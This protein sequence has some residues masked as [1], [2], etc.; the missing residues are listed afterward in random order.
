MKRHLLLLGLLISLSGYSQQ[1]VLKSVTDLNDLETFRS[2]QPLSIHHLGNDFLVGTLSGNIPEGTTVLKQDPWNAGADY[3]LVWLPEGN[4]KAALDKLAGSS[5]L[6]YSDEKK[7]IVETDPASQPGP[8]P[9]VHGGVVRISPASSWQPDAIRSFNYVIDTFPEIYNLIALVDTGEFMPTI[10]HLESYGTRYCELPQAVEAQ[11]WIKAKFEEYQALQV[12][13]QDFPFGSGS[14][15]NVIATLPGKVTP[16]QY[17][18]VGSHY[19]SYAWGGN[20]PGADDNASGTAAVLELAR[21]LSQF[22]FDKSIVFC[23]FSAEEVGLV[24]SEYYASHAQQQ[25][26]DILGYFNFDMISY[27]HGNDPIHTDMIAP[28]SAS[29]LVNFYKGVVA[30][31]LPDFQVYSAQLSGGDSDHTSF[32]NNGYMG[33]FPF[34]DVPNYSPYIHTAQD[35]VGISVNSP[36]MASTFIQANLA[37]VVSLAVP[38]N[39][40]GIQDKLIDRTTLH[41]FP[42]PATSHV[43]LKSLVKESQHVSIYSSHGQKVI[44]QVVTGQMTIDI[45]SLSAGVYIV[46]GI[47]TAGSAFHRLII[48]PSK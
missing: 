29:E 10:R 5:K 3:F 40:V 42:N 26:M 46:K 36:E 28:L 21:I 13:L 48:G 24:G 32:N 43:T 45:T 1:L 44:E 27:R 17:I 23:T 22:E 7:A 37:S 31:Y 30:I 4:S 15:D 6:L 9:F 33:I 47:S 18:V 12:E 8:E 14:S 16:D 35:V 25:G 19:D 34:E 38:Y 2:S 20:A 41:I 11:N 39:P